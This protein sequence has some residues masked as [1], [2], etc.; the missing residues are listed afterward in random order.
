VSRSG[1]TEFHGGLRSFNRN[2]ALNANNFFNNARGRDAQGKEILPRPLY[3][4]ITY[5]YDVGGPVYLPR[6]GKGGRG[7]K[8]IDKLFFF[9]N[10]E[11]YRQLAPNPQRSIRVPT[12][13][14][15]SGDFSNSINQGGGRAFIF[16]PTKRLPDGRQFPCTVDHTLSNP[17]GCFVSNNRL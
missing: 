16:D 5:G 4:Y 13:A 6:F 7:V 11:F 12:L 9:V 1:S 3:R 8:E 17:G 2:E 15:R 10:Q 14:E